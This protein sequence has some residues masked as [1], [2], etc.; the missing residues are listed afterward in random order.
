MNLVFVLAR[1]KWIMRATVSL[2]GLIYGLID[3]AEDLKGLK[4]DK[5]LMLGVGTSSDPATTRLSWW[6]IRNKIQVIHFVGNYDGLSSKGYR[7]FPIAHLAV[8]GEQMKRDA[9]DRHDVPETGITMI[10]ALRYNL[11]STSETRDRNAFF[12]RMGLDFAAATIVFAGSSYDFHYFEM[13][14]AFK[15]LK[16][17]LGRKLQLI[18]RIYPDKNILDSAY[19]EVLMD[20][21]GRCDDIW[22]SVGDPKFK[23][24]AGR[25]EVLQIEESDLWNILEFADVVVN[26]YSTLTLEACMFDKPVINMWY[27]HEAARALKQPIYFPYPLAQH[28]RRVEASGAVTTATSR[29]ELIE[30]LR[31][32]IKNPDRHSTARKNLVKVEC[33]CLDGAAAERLAKMFA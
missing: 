14:G 20:Y 21:A 9:I 32:S 23:Q 4:V 31:D 1:Y 26:I 6:A 22:I 5:L 8:W 18:I 7:G 12:K 13:L 3:K 11:I 27:F 30:Q 2:E 17:I 19:I 28:I 33:G 10:G 24:R 25:E 15:Q 29:K 16:Q